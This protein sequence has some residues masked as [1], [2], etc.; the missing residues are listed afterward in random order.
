MIGSMANY[1]TGEELNDFLASVLADYEEELVFPF[2]IG[3]SHEGRPIM[4]YAFMLGTTK[5][6]FQEELV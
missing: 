5:E 4:A 3:D 2:S 6:L 1:L